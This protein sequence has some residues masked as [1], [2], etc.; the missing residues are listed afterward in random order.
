M[1]LIG[2]QMLN[3][4]GE[5]RN[6]S[7]ESGGISMVGGPMVTSAPSLRRHRLLIGI[8]CPPYEMKDTAT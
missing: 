7:A 1:P 4:L 6:A 8:S 3:P 5:R 2:K